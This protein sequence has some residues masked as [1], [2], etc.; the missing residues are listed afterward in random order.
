MQPITLRIKEQPYK[1]IC[2]GLGGVH[3]AIQ[4]LNMLTAQTQWFA[5]PGGVSLRGKDLSDNH[6]KQYKFD[7]VYNFRKLTP[8][9]RVWKSFDL[10]E[11]TAN[12]VVFLVGEYLDE[13]EHAINHGIY[14]PENIYY[15]TMD[16]IKDLR[17]VKEAIQKTKKAS[18]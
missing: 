18:D 3:K 2:H 4:V 9:S 6:V 5:I 7:D 10:C 14:V 1:T 17:G 16:R 8:Y 12:P 15:Q 13:L 11:L